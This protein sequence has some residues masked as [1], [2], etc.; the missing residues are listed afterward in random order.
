MTNKYK[1]FIS[2][3][4]TGLDPKKARKAFDNMEEKLRAFG[5]EPVN[6]YTI[7]YQNQCHT[8]AEY[9]INGLEQLQYCDGLIQLKG[10]NESLGCHTELDFALGANIQIFQYW[11]VDTPLQRKWMLQRMD[12]VRAAKM[13]IQ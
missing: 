2:G 11:D 12:E 1:I 4:I 8:W 7:P 9:V 6:P 5:F 3:P 10:W 13:A